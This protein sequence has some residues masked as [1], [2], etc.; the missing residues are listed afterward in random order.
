MRTLLVIVLSVMASV[1][2]LA[3]DG[4]LTRDEAYARAQALEAL[5]RKL[6]FDPAL[7]ASGKMACATCHDPA[8]GFAPANA[9]SVQL[10]GK[11][12]R[13]A[14]IRNVPSLTY[15]QSVPAFSQHFFESEDEG[16]S[17][18]DNGPTGG[19]A[20]DGRADRG[21]DQARAPLLSLFEM[22]NESPQAVVARAR[23]ARYGLDLRAIDPATDKTEKAFSVILAA[24]EAFEQSWRDFY[25]YSS[26]YDFYLAGRVQR[27]TI[28]RRATVRIVIT[29]RAA[30]TA[31]RRSSRT[32]ASLRSGCRAIRRSPPMRTRSFTISACAGRCGRILRTKPSIA[33]SF[34]RRVYVMLRFA[35]ASSTTA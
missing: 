5:G 31:P 8:H 32:L 35:R 30:M 6:F 28:R 13:Q 23:A 9:A 24:L 7:S 4:A 3:Q 27:S 25:P 16:D 1:G 29:A 2:A 34:A 12:M 14:G 20:W 11:D 17:S 19:L 18:I 15:L 33:A 21:R 22:A 26:K 10:G